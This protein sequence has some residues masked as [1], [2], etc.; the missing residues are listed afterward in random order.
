V[1][2]LDQAILDYEVWRG[3]HISLHRAEP[4]VCP[5]KFVISIC[6]LRLQH[7]L[8]GFDSRRHPGVGGTGFTAAI[9]AQPTRDSR[10]SIRINFEAICM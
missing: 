3:R 6:H 5:S 10:I 1:V 8:D 7:T 9:T 2:F 4:R